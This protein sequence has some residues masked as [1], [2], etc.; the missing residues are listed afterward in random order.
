[1]SDKSQAQKQAPEQIV[2]TVLGP[3]PGS[4]FSL[5]PRREALLLSELAEAHDAYVWH[6]AKNNEGSRTPTR[7]DDEGEKRQRQ[8]VRLALGAL[9]KSAQAEG[10]PAEYLLP[11]VE[12]NSDLGDLLF[13]QQPRSLKPIQRR[14]KT[15]GNPGSSLKRSA[16]LAFACAG[17][18]VLIHNQRGATKKVQEVETEIA[19]MIDI[20]VGALRSWR[21]ALKSRKKS[22]QAYRIYEGALSACRQEPDPRQAAYNL[23]KP[24]RRH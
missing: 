14:E 20:E 12:L 23:L 2:R 3:L 24:F 5:G 7:D 10:I 15:R 16:K 4:F 17:I 11:V 22:L 9:I 13:G 19:R 1:M 6:E 8:A 21:K 18:D